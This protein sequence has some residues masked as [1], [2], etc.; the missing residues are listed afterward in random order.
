MILNSFYY[1]IIFPLL[2]L[3]YYYENKNYFGGT[4]I[5][6]AK[7]INYF[8]NYMLV[9]ASLRTHNKEISITHSYD[10]HGNRI[11]ISTSVFKFERACFAKNDSIGYVKLINNNGKFFLNPY[12]FDLSPIMTYPKGPWIKSATGITYFP[13]AVCAKFLTHTFKNHDGLIY[14]QRYNED[15]INYDEHDI[16]L[17]DLGHFKKK[18]AVGPI[19]LFIFS[20][21]F[22][23]MLCCYKT[24]VYLCD[25][26]YN[27]YKFE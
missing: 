12:S 27:R 13:G 9:C 7:T 5:R 25:Y 20:L 19:F 4:W 3:I 10:N 21:I 15:C 16:L 24:I 1:F 2:L 26:R 22:M 8:D 6:S 17:E 14:E 11:L 18:F 23:F